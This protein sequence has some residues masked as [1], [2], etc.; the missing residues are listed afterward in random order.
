MN[1]EFEVGTELRVIP[2]TDD[3]FERLEHDFKLSE[4][5]GSIIAKAMK[6]LAC[7]SITRQTNAWNEVFQ[8]ANVDLE[9]EKCEVSWLRRAIIVRKRDPGEK[10]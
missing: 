2:L 4:E 5:V 3:Q 6:E 9:T 8:L 10:P 1:K 7:E